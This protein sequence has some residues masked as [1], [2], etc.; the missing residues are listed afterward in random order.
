MRKVI[1]GFVV[2][3]SILGIVYFLLAIEQLKLERRL[4]TSLVQQNNTFYRSRINDVVFD[5]FKMKAKGPSY[6]QSID[7][8]FVCH[9]M[10]DT[11][12][13]A[14]MAPIAQFEGLKAMGEKYTK[15]Y[16]AFTHNLHPS[17][18]EV[19][20]YGL[21]NDKEDYI[22]FSFYRRENGTAVD[23]ISKR[24]DTKINTNE[25]NKKSGFIYDEKWIINGFDLDERD[26]V[27]QQHWGLPIVQVS[28]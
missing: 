24:F 16:D 17:R 11:S 12:L 9:P 13:L 3:S 15:Y 2:I 5:I 14:D 10:G 26:R 27:L 28:K 7:S 1:Y 22:Q 21:M 25:N 6:T 4:L 18:S 19:F 23:H 8:F 20:A